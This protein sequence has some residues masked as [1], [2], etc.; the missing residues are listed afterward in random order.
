MP[1]S[2]AAPSDPS[3]PRPSRRAVGRS[4]LVGMIALIV[5]ALM[6]WSIY[7]RALQI[8]FG[9]LRERG[10][11]TL[12]LAEASLRGQLARFERLPGLLAEERAVRSLLL[13]PGDQ[14]LV[15]LANLYLR[16]TA[17]R[18]G[19]SDIY[20][21][22]RDGLTLAA[23]NFDQPHSFVGG[24]F[25]F[26]PYFRDAINGGEGRF[27][28]LGTT[29]NKRGYY[30]GAPV[31]VG[32]IVRGVL[33]IKIDLDEIEM[34][35]AS[36]DL[37][38]VVM[39]PEGI[40][41]LSNRP[42][43]L[44]RALAPLGPDEARRTRETRRYANAEV[45]VVQA[46]WSEAQG[47]FSLLQAT[48][49]GTETEYLLTQA[50]MAD[51]GWTVIVLSP[52][53]GARQQALLVVAALLLGLGAVGFAGLIVWLRR[54][55]LAERIALQAA[56][57]AQLERRVVERTA[58]LAA[59]NSALRQ[60]VEERIATEARLRDTQAELVQAGKLA[61]LGQMSAALSHEFNQPLA[62]AR[63]YA[64]NAGVYLERGQVAEAERNIGHIIGMIERMGRISR[65]LR[66]FARKPH[67]K[68]RGVSVA[69]VV[70]EAQDLLGWR[71]AQAGAE[72][73]VEI[74]PVDLCVT[75]GAVRL[76][77]VLVN[78]LTNALDATE[79]AAD[80]R[81]H[82]SARRQGDMAL[83][84]LRD[85]GPGV[86][87]QVLARIF[88]PFFS[89]KGVGKGLGLGLSISYN[90]V[91]DFGGTLEVRNP[92]EG[93]AEFVLRLRAAEADTPSAEAAE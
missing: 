16:E 56:T 30:F 44:F 24:N 57:Q 83:L 45:G 15:G 2:P 67:Q 26:R 75:A 69:A 7:A 3:P 48:A 87:D 71:L 60:E 47:G 86:P 82:L 37:R 84:C 51:A 74:E 22:S 13:A 6:A 63:N 92:P 32:G 35:W 65:H 31:D 23:S 11:N 18:L 59:V 46:V 68:L 73:I 9:D 41:F 70:Q 61:A 40:V 80:R 85:H 53:A 42:D 34:A 25:A 27:F 54:R 10:E 4:A 93:G 64:E 79:D 28:A 38:I 62:A 33:V 1:T 81:L 12:R 36:N 20:V 19:A 52:T 77:Q 55:Q 49:D 89:T 29:S 39:D 88:D 66:N 14:A 43:W 91:R 21:M 8:T 58:E 78:L 76:Q 17:R 72:L 50:E 90:I 5:V